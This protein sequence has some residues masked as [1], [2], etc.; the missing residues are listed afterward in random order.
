MVTQRSIQDNAEVQMKIALSPGR[1]NV[2]QPGCRQTEIWSGTSFSRTER[3][4]LRSN[5]WDISF[6]EYGWFCYFHIQVMAFLFLFSAALI[7]V[8]SGV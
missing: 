3:L 6:F 4:A 5:S 1:W 2:E 8:L 7:L